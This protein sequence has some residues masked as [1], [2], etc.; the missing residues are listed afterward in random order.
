M[1]QMTQTGLERAGARLRLGEVLGLALLL[2][3]KRGGIGGIKPR[4]TILVI[5]VAPI[6][7]RD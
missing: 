6:R 1:Q 4:H 2:E 5:R 3:R 7:C